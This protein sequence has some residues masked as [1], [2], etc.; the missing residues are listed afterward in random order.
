MKVTILG[1]NILLFIFMVRY[2]FQNLTITGSIVH[3]GATR[4]RK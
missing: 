2:Y 1:I 4:K 3:D